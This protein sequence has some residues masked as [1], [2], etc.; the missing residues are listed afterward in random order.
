MPLTPRRA[1][2]VLTALAMLT[3]TLAGPAAAQAPDPA[4]TYATAGVADT[5]AEDTTADL[6]AL[7]FAFASGEIG[8]D[9]DAPEVVPGSLLVTTT[10]GVALDGV[11]ADVAAPRFAAAGFASADAI[12]S[13]VA[14]VRTAEGSEVEVARELASLPGVIAVEPNLINEWAA[15]PNDEL[16]G[17]Q[18]AHQ[19][20]NIEAAWDVSVGNGRPLVAV[21]DSGVAG[22]HPDLNGIVVQS[23]QAANGQVA[24]GQLA[25]DECGIGH[26]TAVAG[27]VGARG[28]NGGGVSG[29]LWEPRIIDVALTSNRNGCPPGPPDDATIAAIEAMASLPEPP[30]AIN[31]SLGGDR[32]ACPAAYTAA[33]NN[34]RARGIVVVAAAGNNGTSGTSVPASCDGVISVGAT[35]SQNQRADYSQTN[36]FVDVAAP[37]G[38]FPAE[39]TVDAAIANMILTTCLPGNGGQTLGCDPGFAYDVITGTS[40]S[41]P[42]IAAVVALIRS[43]VPSLSIDQ[44]QAVIENT[45][46]DLGGP[47]RDVEFGEGLVDV[48]AALA[49]AQGGEGLILGPRPSFPAEGGAPPTP[50]PPG[51]T[52]EG[53]IR[54]ST[55]GAT[56]P[57]AQAVAVSS[58][59]PDQSAA[60]VVL[61]RV[62]NFADA[63]SGS[64]V[65]YGL[66]PLLYTTSTGPLASATAAEIQR[67]LPP[68]GQV[69]LMGGTAALPATLEGELQAMGYRIIRL[70]G[71]S[72]FE[73]AALGSELVEEIKAVTDRRERDFA[74]VTFAGN[75]PDAVGAGQMASYFGIPILVTETGALNDV[76]RQALTQLQPSRVFLVGGTA[77]LSDAVAQQIGALGLSVDRLAGPSRVET[78]LAVSVLMFNELVADGVDS[79]I[80]TV[81]VN[82]R[83]DFTHVLS[84]TLISTF[85]NLFVPLEG[86]DGSVVTD[87]VLGVYCGF[88]ALGGQHFLAGGTDVITDSAA[89]TLDQLYSQPQANC[90]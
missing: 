42:Y 75:W 8:S 86:D 47:G 64:A 58:G 78:S 68:G 22:D 80:G 29:V 63:L 70:A 25:N 50:P 72:R 55:G 26:G 43:V 88:S 20:T 15:A 19:R 3:T 14:L 12:G 46:Q 48:A 34:A 35:G 90:A 28:N 4:P 76:T 61:A 13:Q 18:W 73:T 27:V 5:A 41:S 53:I 24:P 44:V 56:D 16:Y 52:P 89:V 49:A 57:I 84:A 67:V 65:G 51:G 30:L 1:V 45:A 71:N 38:V 2:V 54:V 36:D 77:V 21:L 66:G 79:G 33:I 74:F 17:A 62:D 81:A 6:A 87:P 82:L 40:F 9:E 85:G 60:H 37:G 23:L 31:L 59:L 11:L 39:Q 7:R 10:D 69:V 83:R 32:P